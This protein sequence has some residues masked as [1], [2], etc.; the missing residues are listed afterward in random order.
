MQLAMNYIDYTNGAFAIGLALTLIKH[1]VG[2]LQLRKLL[3]YL[4]FSLTT[5]TFPEP[6]TPSSIHEFQI[7]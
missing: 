7:R 6:R 4:H 3:T 2:C 1:I 5:V